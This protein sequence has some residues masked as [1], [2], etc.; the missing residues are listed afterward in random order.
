MK[1]SSLLIIP[2]IAFVYACTDN[3]LEGIDES[4]KTE[5]DDV[6]TIS[7]TDNPS[8]SYFL[9]KA[10]DETLD[11]EVAIINWSNQDTGTKATSISDGLSNTF[12][13]SRVANSRWTF[14]AAQFALDLNKTGAKSADEEGF[15]WYLP[16]KSELMLINIYNGCLNLSEYAYWSSTE[17]V[18]FSYY[19]DHA[20]LIVPNTSLPGLSTMKKSDGFHYADAKKKGAS[21]RIVKKNN[22][23]GKKYPYVKSKTEPIIVSRDKDG[24]VKEEALRKEFPLTTTSSLEDSKVSR[25]FEVDMSNSGWASLTE[26]KTLCASKGA[27]WRVPTLKEMQLIWAMGGSGNQDWKVYVANEGL[28][29]RDVEGFTPLSS[30]GDY[31]ISNPNYQDCDQAGHEPHIVGWRFESAMGTI[32]GGNDKDGKE[33]VRC[34]RDVEVN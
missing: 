8:Q 28:N 31:M 20:W 15:D 29:L 26:A 2:C 34:V 6:A 27:N 9:V 7:Y 11:G 30:Y 23:E 32:I 18:N 21:V 4:K 17:N 13:L 14:P 10:T 19:R 12:E 1:I 25:S 33:T 3:S 24:G 22:V 5:S 16:S